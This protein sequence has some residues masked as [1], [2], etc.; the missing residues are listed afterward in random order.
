[1]HC[2]A[3]SVGRPFT[4]EVTSCKTLICC[5]CYPQHV[6]KSYLLTVNHR[7]H[8]RYHIRSSD[9]PYK[10]EECGHGFLHKKDLDRHMPRHTGQKLFHCSIQ[11]CSKTYT[12]KDN[13]SRHIRHDHAGGSSLLPVAIA[14]DYGTADSPNDVSDH[15]AR[16]IAA[17]QASET[18]SVQTPTAM[19]EYQSTEVDHP[20]SFNQGKRPAEEDPGRLNEVRA[21]KRPPRKSPLKH[22]LA[23]PYRKCR[24]GQFSSQPRYKVCA[25]TPHEYIRRVIDHMDRNHQISVCGGCFFAFSSPEFL[26]QHKDSTEHCGKCYLSFPDK[27]AISAHVSSCKSVES[28]SQE[29]VWHIMYETLCADYIRHN[30]SFDEEGPLD[31]AIQPNNL[32]RMRYINE[33]A[34][35]PGQVESLYQKDLQDS[36]NGNAPAALNSIGESHQLV[37]AAVG[38]HSMPTAGPSELQLL[39]A[40]VRQLSVRDQQRQA[41]VLQHQR[42]ITVLL[43]DN[44]RHAKRLAAME[45]LLL[46]TDS[47]NPQA[48]GHDYSHPAQQIDC[49]SVI[50]DNQELMVVHPQHLNFPTTKYLSPSS[51]S[52]GDILYSSANP[53][54]ELHPLQCP[55]LVSDTTATTQDF[56]TS[57]NV[58]RYGLPGGEDPNDSMKEKQRSF[59]HAWGV[60]SQDDYFTLE[61]TIVPESASNANERAAQEHEPVCSVCGD[62]VCQVGDLCT[63]CSPPWPS[64][65]G[66]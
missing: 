33:H 48:Y 56:R 15:S 57:T 47:E 37:P 12:R 35:L 4:E 38:A 22:R 36:G 39:R 59:Q 44:S 24:P 32:A 6:I 25:T 10:C 29:D 16:H 8:T 45:G 11:G 63:A 41:Q 5:L 28:S 58:F 23:C 43:D 9:R 62:K 34:A 21:A 27:A 53:T 64:L 52:D 3:T 54:H 19:D 13:L 14:E 60:T 40:E 42:V 49:Q 55:S 7:H 31:E 50:I 20:R 61:E 66:T 2:T 1:M 30:P 46:P 17:G 51:F 65:E 26:K 18:E